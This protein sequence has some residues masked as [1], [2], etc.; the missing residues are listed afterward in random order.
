MGA[1]SQP[2]THPRINVETR[3]EVELFLSKRGRGKLEIKFQLPVAGSWDYIFLGL[4]NKPIGSA[5]NRLTDP[6]SPKI[7]WDGTPP[8]PVRR[9]IIHQTRI[10]GVKKEEWKLWKAIK[11][12][13]RWKVTLK[14]NTRPVAVIL[15]FSSGSLIRDWARVA[16][17]KEEEKQRHANL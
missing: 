6:N 15:E 10:G 7:S 8:A 17:I 1:V 16:L 2:Q 13:P 5:A 9:Y 12:L 11:E 3:Y 4:L 14:C